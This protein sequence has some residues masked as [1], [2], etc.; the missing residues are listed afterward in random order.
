MK[1]MVESANLPE[2][3]VIIRGDVTG[4]EISSLLKL[5]RIKNSE[6]L[7]LCKEEEQFII[8]VRD[9]VYIETGGSR[10]LVH[11]HDNTYESKE[12]LYELRDQL[13]AHAFVQINKSTL[14]NIDCVKSIQ[15]E[16]SGNFC[17]RLKQRKE[18]LVVSRKYFKAFKESI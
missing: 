14:V 11:T 7:V 3:E 6:K 15:A 1:I 16:F 17:I 4:D 10:V 9:I 13:S 5:L 12:K 8:A 2:T 18:T